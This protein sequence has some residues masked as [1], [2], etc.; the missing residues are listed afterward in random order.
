MSSKFEYLGKWSVVS[1]LPP[2]TG[3]GE[4]GVL[5]T[6]QEAGVVVG[7]ACRAGLGLQGASPA[8][9]EC[10]T[11]GVSP[12]GVDEDVSNAGG[13]VV[14]GTSWGGCLLAVGEVQG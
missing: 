14:V 8:Y 12:V 7:V 13:T 1:E 3:V 10:V 4:G 11:V 9:V 2:H 6:A 5:L